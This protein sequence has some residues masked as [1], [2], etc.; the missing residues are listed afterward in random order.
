MAAQQNRGTSD[1]AILVTLRAVC[2]DAHL[3]AKPGRLANNGGLGESYLCG[4]QP[5]KKNNSST[6]EKERGLRGRDERNKGSAF[7]VAALWDRV[8]RSTEKK[9]FLGAVPPH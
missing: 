4:I 7:K 2:R 6:F 9:A 5:K 8:Y 3:F 1:F